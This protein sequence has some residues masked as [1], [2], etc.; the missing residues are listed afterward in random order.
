MRV[1]VRITNSQHYA[2]VGNDL[3]EVEGQTVGECLRH[4][5]KRFPDITN[6][7]FTE[8][9]KLQLN[10]CILLNKYSTDPDPLN[11]PVQ[12]GEEIDIY[13]IGGG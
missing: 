6:E 11:C 1:K 13:I 12:S 3:G 9:G 10:V 7:L 2:G 5:I 4:I 8:G